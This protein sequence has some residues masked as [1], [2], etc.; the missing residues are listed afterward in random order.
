[1][2][3]IVLVLVSPAV[4]GCVRGPQRAPS[5]FT[6]S[7]LNFSYTAPLNMRDFTEVDN[8]SIQ[9]RAKAMGKTNMLTRLLSLRSGS[10]DTAPEWHS[11]GI[12][13]YPREK[14]G[15]VTDRDACQTLSRS[16]AR[17]GTEIGQPLDVQIGDVHF[18]AST[19]EMREGELI[20][21][22]R[23][24]TTVRNG[25]MLSFAFSANSSE[26]LNK[27]ADSMKTFAPG[28]TQK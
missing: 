8:Q 24:Y 13:T 15:I 16:V 17:G 27:I 2:K 28:K 11:I 9:Q 25:Q 4:H 14:M 21:R 18:V 23:V 12:Q 20:K 1:M 3:R 6:E 22:A 10:D 7:A 26:V 19:F 5:T